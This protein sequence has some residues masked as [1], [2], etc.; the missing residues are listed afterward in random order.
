MSIPFIRWPVGGGSTGEKQKAADAL[1]HERRRVERLCS[2]IPVLGKFVSG[3]AIASDM[4]YMPNRLLMIQ[5]FPKMR[6][7]S[8]CIA[9]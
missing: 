8:C 7:D 9:A 1:R 5:H 2:D 3:D 6:G 4:T